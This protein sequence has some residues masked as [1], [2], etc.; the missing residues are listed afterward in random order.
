MKLTTRAKKIPGYSQIKGDM[1]VDDSGGN[2]WLKLTYDSG[3][4]QCIVELSK[5][6][7][8][9][10]INV[11]LRDSEIVAGCKRQ[12]QDILEGFLE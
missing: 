10:I 7:V 5:F 2:F 4:S 8:A 12:D 3:K 11:G 9:R 1:S 6:E